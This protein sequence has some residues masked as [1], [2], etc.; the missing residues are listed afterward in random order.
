MLLAGFVVGVAAA[1][2]RVV[3]PAGLDRMPERLEYVAVAIPEAMKSGAADD[4]VTMVAIISAEGRVEKLEEVRSERPESAGIAKAAVA[5]WVFTRG[6]AAGEPVMFRLPVTI[7][8][9][10]GQMSDAMADAGA[11]VG[12]SGRLLM[13]PEA[14]YETVPAYPAALKE[15]PVDGAATISLLVD[16]DGRPSDAVVEF[17]SRAEFAA[18]ALEAIKEWSFS[19]AR[20]DGKPFAARTN[21]EARFAAKS[22]GWTDEERLL[23]SQLQYARNYDKGP[24][25]KTSV[26]VVF[27]Y[28]ALLAKKVGGVTLNV[29][30]DPSGR[31]VQ[32]SP[33]PG[34]NAGFAAAAG[35]SLAGWEFTP[36]IRAGRPVFGLVTMQFT[37]DE[38]RDEF[39]FDSSSLELLEGLRAGTAVIHSLKDVDQMPKPT[40][41]VAPALPRDYTGVGVGEALIEFIIDRNGRAR[42]P[43]CARA[44]T[45]ELGWAAAT[46]VAQWRFEPARKAGEAVDVKARVP[47]NFTDKAAGQ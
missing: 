23:Q 45:P 22:A 15:A 37:F 42:F 34:A 21:V 29:L 47:I 2:I 44:T 25:Q 41:R 19:P 39:D 9:R 20:R 43:R 38:H 33:G 11:S 24:G 3:D 36:A 7:A 1:R 4:T 35:A 30:V 8:I 12:H 40:R 46:A 17:A 5:Q 32:T 16:E 27:P 18:P 10:P 13:A 28:E 6:T 14:V 26:P 31:V